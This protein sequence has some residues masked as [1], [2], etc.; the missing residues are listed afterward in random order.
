MLSDRNGAN[1]NPY[2]FTIN[3][4]PLGAPYTEDGSIN[5]SQTNDA[6][7]TN[8]LAEL[9]PGA[10]VDNTKRYRVFNSVYAEVK[11]IDGLKYR[12]NFGPDLTIGKWG[13]YIGAQTNARKGGDPLASNENRFGFNWTIE[14]ILNYN[15]SYGKHN[16][17]LTAV[18]SIQRDNYETY[19]VN[20]QGVP[21]RTQEYHNLGNASLIL[22]ATSTL[23]EWTI[24]SY[25]ARLNYDFND[26][27]LLTL[28]LR[29][30]GSSRFG[31]NTKYGNFPGIA[32]GWNMSN[33]EFLSNV[34]WLDMLKLRAGWGKVGNQGVA[35]YQTQGL[36]GRTVY[37]WDSSPAF[38]YRP[39]TIG[40]SDLRWESS[41]TANFGVDFSLFRGRLQGSLELYQTNTTDLL[42]S[43][44]L[45]GS[46]GF[47]AATKNVGETRN[48]G[49]ELG[50]SSINVNT[51]GGFRWSTDFQFTKN[52]EAIVS[53]YNGK[54]DDLGNRWFIGHPLNS[55]FDYKKEGIWQES[56][57]EEAAKFYPGDR[58]NALGAGV[59]QIKVQ[60]TN[61]DGI[62]NANDRVLL[63]SD[64]PDFSLGI[65]NR[66]NYKNF[67]LSFF[68]FGRFGQ[69]ITSGFH[70]NNNALAGRYQQI[71][72][73]YW[74]PDNPNAEYPRPFSSQEFP[75]Y[76]TTLIYF[77]GSFI[78]LR[79]VNA[80]YTFA[81]TVTK[82]IGLE[83]LRVFT[84]IQQPKIWAKFI[85]KYNGVDPE[86]S[87]TAINNGITPST[88]VITVGINA[89][90]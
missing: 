65:T 42:L 59:G 52:T 82:K 71:K 63:G 34:S 57:V 90:F 54:V 13:R 15:K 89:R 48:R 32:V 61:R 20:V 6:L 45:L 1:L 64:V 26:K 4:N 5:F 24:N 88:R 27:Y 49:I 23:T 28:T 73:D 86:T 39:A 56:E 83:S 51:D 16:L 37:A 66:F 47:S 19:G 25:L 12:V 75:Q 18:H 22:G 60:D 78:K 31:E 72:V 41:A 84:S 74:T 50:I 33:E 79:N 43:D 80:G 8:P 68:L 70:Q 38:G 58:N 77:D 10:Q 53:L 67:D 7:L 36:L 21:V 17:N 85:S 87:G 14:N 81:N 44:Q 29:R 76:N 69:M 40:N 30:D 11:I 3:Q 46:I 35:P 55:F 2:S 62:I 9:V